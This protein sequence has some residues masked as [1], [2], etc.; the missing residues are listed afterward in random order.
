M[1]Y[2]QNDVTPSVAPARRLTPSRSVNKSFFPFKMTFARLS[3]FFTCAVF[4]FFYYKRHG[5]RFVKYY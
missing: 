4:L 5:A 1:E 2:K 3:S